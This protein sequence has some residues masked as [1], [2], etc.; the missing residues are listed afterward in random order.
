MRALRR[1]LI[2]IT[3]CMTI[4]SLPLS[5]LH[6]AEAAKGKSFPD[7][8]ISHWAYQTI[9]WAGEEGIIKGLPSGHAAPDRLVTQAE[10]TAM[11]NRAFVPTSKYQ[12]D[13]EQIQVPAGSAWDLRDYTFAVHMNWAVS[14]EKRSNVMNRGEVA[15][16]LVSV[17]GLT[18][19][20][21]GSIQYLLDN[22]LA[23]GKTS[24]TIQGYKGQ[25]LLTRAEAVTFIHNMYTAGVEIAPRVRDTN[26]LC[27]SGAKQAEDVTIGG[28]MLHDSE[29]K[30]YDLLGE[31]ELVVRSQYGFDWHIYNSNY[32]KYVQVG[33]QDGRVVGLLT[34]TANWR[35]PDGIGADSDYEDVLRTYGDPLK[36]M[37]SGNARE[38]TVYLRDDYYMTIYYDLHEDERIAAVQ[39]IDKAVEES[40]QGHYAEP[41]DELRSS[42]E[43]QIFEL[44]NATRVSRGLEAFVWDDRAATSAYKH[45]K[46]MVEL[47][48]FHHRDPAGLSPFDRMEREGI[49]Y[50]TAAE[51]I[52]YG[53][54]DALEV[55][56][57]WM[58]SEGHR[59]A[60][61]DSYERLGVGVAFASNG[62]PYYTQNFYTPRKILSLL[63]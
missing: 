48:F 14:Q 30:V 31:T 18:C 55:H 42:F 20:D 39:L 2:T 50:S 53:Q 60:L 37:M 13:Y 10:F 62:S 5:T 41:S 23:K 54:A 58:N 9:V 52:A 24:A 19:S 57:G 44:A 7:L 11:I 17:M 28:I 27:P 47:E 12:V 6:A 25:D 22:G 51:N 35:S 33:I 36:Y 34:N 26:S 15:R 61:L 32:K 56:I 29:A 8:P 3:L 4:L 21:N 40:L 63:P 43:R 16:L 59:K 1:F 38:N 46:N 49:V 45:S